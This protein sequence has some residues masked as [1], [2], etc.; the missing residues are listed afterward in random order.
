MIEEIVCNTMDN[1][2]ADGYRI[3][4]N[5]CVSDDM[6]MEMVGGAGLHAGNGIESVVNVNGVG[7][8][9]P[10]DFSQSRPAV[11]SNEIAY[12][13]ITGQRKDSKL[14]YTIDERQLYYCK[15][16]LNKRSVYVCSDVDCIAQ[17][18]VSLGGVCTKS[19]KHGAHEHGDNSKCSNT[20]NSVK[21]IF[22]MSP[23]PAI[24]QKPQPSVM[25]TCK[26]LSSEYYL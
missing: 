26:I 14:L 21:K 20:C 12:R 25:F 2:M 17:V 11:P 15:N 1:E 3:E 13:F 22:E 10:V 18:N 16:V 6:A 23:K 5:V 9:M 7:S 19:V 24:Y 8:P 4:F